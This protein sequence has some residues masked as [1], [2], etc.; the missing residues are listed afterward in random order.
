MEKM[1][2]AN[3]VVVLWIAGIVAA[4]FVSIVVI[5]AIRLWLRRPQ[6]YGLEGRKSRRDAGK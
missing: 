5:D 4:I 2:Y 1:S 6:V 3:A